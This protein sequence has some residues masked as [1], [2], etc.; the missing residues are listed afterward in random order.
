M[1][2]GGEV[3]LLP[4]A[5][6]A[7]TGLRAG[8]AHRGEREVLQHAVQAVGLAQ[9]CAYQLLLELQ[10][11]ARH[12]VQQAAQE[13]SLLRLHHAVVQ[14]VE[15][16]QQPQVAQVERREPV[17]EGLPVPLGHRLQQGL[18]PVQQLLQG[19]VG[20]VPEALVSSG[21]EAASTSLSLGGVGTV[22]GVPRGLW[23]SA[24]LRGFQK[25]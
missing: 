1:P 20:G 10:H 18:L 14:G 16:A 6:L 2:K 21:E 23:R 15:P 22:G 17:L 4:H 12:A 25:V 9:V 3:H 5:P 24:N 8:P 13:P 19:G 7:W 11:A